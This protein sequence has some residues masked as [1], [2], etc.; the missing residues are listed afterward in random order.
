MQTQ[1]GSR[2]IAV[3]TLNNLGASWMWVVKATL[4]PFYPRKHPRHPLYRRLSGPQSR[5]GRVWK[6]E[7]LLPTPGFEPR[8]VQPVASR[9]TD[10]AIPLC[11]H[12]PS[13]AQRNVWLSKMDEWNCNLQSVY[14]PSVSRFTFLPQH[15]RHFKFASPLTYPKCAK[16]WM[17]EKSRMDLAEGELGSTH[18]HTQWVPATCRMRQSG[19]EVKLITRLHPLPKLRICGAIPPLSIRFQGVALR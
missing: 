14:L 8:T 11:H 1:K 18:P 10:Y 12:S 2:G 9:Y 7:N 5:F 4:R 19:R 13:S 15:V 17:S 3:P 16:F 6:S